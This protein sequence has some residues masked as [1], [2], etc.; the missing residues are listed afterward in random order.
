[1]ENIIGVTSYLREKIIENG[2]DPDRD[3]S[4]F[5]SNG[6]GE[7]L[8]YSIPKGIIGVPISLLQ[9]QPAMTRWR[10]R[11]IFTR[12]RLHLAIFR[13]FSQIIR[14]G[15]YMK[16]SRASMTRRLDFRLSVRQ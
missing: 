5:D 16:L 3:D 6:G 1:M 8:L 14:R 10:N 13:D 12:A 11:K 2:G 4:E 15:L 7:A 9:T